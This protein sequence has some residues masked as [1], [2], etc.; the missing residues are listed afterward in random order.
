MQ[1]T[2][3]AIKL[4]EKGLIPDAAIRLGIRQL[5]KTRLDEISAANC[6]A[7]AQ[8]EADFIAAMRQSPIALL[9][10]LANAQHYEL[11]TEFF[12]L[13]LGQ[14]R[15]YSSCFWLPETKNLEEAEAFALQLTC[16]HAELQNGQQILEL[17]CGWGSLTLWMAERFPQSRITAVSNSNSQREYIT[18]TALARGLNN[19]QVIT[20][21]MNTFSPSTFGIDVMFDRV[22]SV[23]M[24]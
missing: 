5:C 15:K 13:C 18:Q 3:E 2:S 12:A 20:C 14:H 22:V 1:F 9:P 24:F 19:I 16:E 21:D 8:I 17:G 4:A 10:D 7:S 23:E 11:P 6:E